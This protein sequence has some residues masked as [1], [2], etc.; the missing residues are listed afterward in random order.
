MDNIGTGIGGV[1][2]MVF[3]GETPWHKK[4]TK[5]AQLFTTKEALEAAGF[6]DMVEIPAMY[7][8]Q[9]NTFNSP[10]KKVILRKDNAS[11][12]STVGIGYKVS[13]YSE[14]LGETMDSLIGEGGAFIETAGILGNGAKGWMQARLPGDIA[15]ERSGGKDVIEKY[16]LAYTAH[17][18]TANASYRITARRVVCQN[19]L[20][21]AFGE[22]NFG[23]VSVRH[24]KNMEK[25]LS[26]VGNILKDAST[27]YAEFAESINLFAEKDLT[28]NLVKDYLNTLIPDKANAKHK[29]RSENIRAEI[30]NLSRVGMGQDMEGVKG[31]LWALYNGVTE[32]VDF[33][34]GTRGDSDDSRAENRLESVFF[35]SGLDMKEDAYKLAL[36]M[37][38]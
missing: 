29:T 3:T 17:D 28:E 8:Y 18:G 27:A 35:G 16:I 21:M 13:Q 2:G 36:S 38:K 10:D 11:Y 33:H 24:S 15:I 19:T 23:L 30:A 22:Q 26:K 31:T 14:S 37:A 12:V 9:G 5:F 7:R 20:E 32:Y 1:V 25:N 4:G 6:P 34:R